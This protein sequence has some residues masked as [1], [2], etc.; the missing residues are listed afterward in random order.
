L[1]PAAALANDVDGA[2][3]VDALHNALGKIRRVPSTR[4]A[5]CSRE[6]SRRRPR[7]GR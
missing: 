1:L 5:S 3:L 4:R 2:D 7:R 6:R